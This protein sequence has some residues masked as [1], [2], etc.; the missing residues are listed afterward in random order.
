MLVP[1][2]KLRS[3]Q[4]VTCGAAAHA[5]LLESPEA[6][7]AMKDLTGSR[8]PSPL[9]RA[10]SQKISKAEV[11][12]V[13]AIGL[14]DHNKERFFKSLST[15]IDSRYFIRD[16]S[17]EGDDEH[18]VREV[19]TGEVA[20]TLLDLCERL[21]L[22]GYLSDTATTEDLSA[23]LIWNDE[24]LGSL[25]GA[26]NENLSPHGM[27]GPR[28]LLTRLGDAWSGVKFKPLI[29]RTALVAVALV[30]VYFTFVGVLVTWRLLGAQQPPPQT[31]QTAIEQSINQPDQANAPQVNAQSQLT[32]PK[33]NEVVLGNLS[34]DDQ[35]TLFVFSDPFCPYC[36]ELEKT[37]ESM[38][39]E[40]KIRIFPSPVHQESYPVIRAIACASSPKEKA[41]IWRKSINEGVVTG[42]TQ[43]DLG[44][45]APEEGLQF[46]RDLGF[47]STPTIISGDGRVRV[48]AYPRDQLMQWAL[49]PQAK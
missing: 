15:F 23:F 34:A 33:N 19:V 37:L 7:K 49:D 40:W 3:S 35:H 47:R 26:S 41:D 13:A 25:F 46:F 17:S 45:A 28:S 29:K 39:S 21:V 32:P 48:G 42:N 44:K 6:S 4:Q 30:I 36:K 12:S 5:A 2:S 27:T 10:L 8:L 14:G 1:D 24:P 16:T 9:Q 43:C 18:L 31:A 22:N 20:Q 11:F 38:E